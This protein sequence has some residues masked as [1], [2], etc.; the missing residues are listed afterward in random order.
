MVAFATATR[1]NKTVKTRRGFNFTACDSIYRY[2]ASY[3]S[4][5]SLD[6]MISFNYAQVI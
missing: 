6:S 1:A 5:Y 2:Q 3:K 4:C